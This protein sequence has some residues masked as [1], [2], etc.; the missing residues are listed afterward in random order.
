MAK[1]IKNS[2][3]VGKPACGGKIIDAL[4][5]EVQGSGAVTASPVVSSPSSVKDIWK[6]QAHHYDHKCLERWSLQ[7]ADDWSCWRDVLR[8]SDSLGTVW[9]LQGKPW[10][11]HLL[12]WA[13]QNCAQCCRMPKSP[14]S[15]RVQQQVPCLGS[16][17][18]QAVPVSQKAGQEMFLPGLILLSM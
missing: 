4:Q 3:C 12:F 2:C 11:V 9:S 13:C 16:R 17:D 14:K 1:Q 5:G 6:I 15:P 8:F 7:S 10:A 18:S